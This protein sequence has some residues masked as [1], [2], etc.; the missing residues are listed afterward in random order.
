MAVTEP[1]EYTQQDPQGGRPW[2]LILST[3]IR[4]QRAN[5]ERKPATGKGGDL[6]R[7]G[8]AVEILSCVKYAQ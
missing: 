8:K 2:N 1:E 6:E 4:D 5:N 3:E 7:A